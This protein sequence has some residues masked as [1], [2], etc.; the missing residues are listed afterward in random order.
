MSIKWE[1]NISDITIYIFFKISVKEIALVYFHLSKCKRF[2]FIFIIH[3]I[4]NML[5]LQLLNISFIGAITSLTL[6][7]V[8]MKTILFYCANKL[9]NFYLFI[10][11]MNLLEIYPGGIKPN[12]SYKFLF[13]YFFFLHYTQ[14]YF[15]CAQS[16]VTNFNVCGYSV[17]AATNLR[18]YVSKGFLLN[19]NITLT[20]VFN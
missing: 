15:F 10:A 1:K 3:R 7:N 4:L 14:G 11:M 5:L 6:W 9:F 8:L 20:H 13:Y 19:S 12:T 16:S 18:L 2:L 17:V